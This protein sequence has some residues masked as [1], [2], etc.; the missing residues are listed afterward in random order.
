MRV[1]CWSCSP[2]RRQTCRCAH[3]QCC[4]VN[5][6]PPDRRV[7]NDD[8]G[9]CSAT[10]RG[11]PGPEEPRTDLDDTS[12]FDDSSVTS[13]RE[14]EDEEDEEEEEDSHV[15]VLLK[16]SSQQYSERSVCLR[17]QIPRRTPHPPIRTP[18]NS[19]TPAGSC[20]KRLV[21]IRTGSPPLRVKSAFRP[22]WDNP[23]KQVTAFNPSL[24]KQQIINFS[25][26]WGGPLCTFF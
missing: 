18:A 3:A 8:S 1:E 7:E 26:F 21:T 20:G 19:S 5:P 4:P 6:E 2:V 16:P 14:G 15:P 13:C 12:A 9:W 11:D 25:F 10:R 17:W 22:I 24:S 23:T